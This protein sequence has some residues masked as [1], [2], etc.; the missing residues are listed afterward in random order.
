MEAETIRKDIINKRLKTIG[1][2]PFSYHMDNHCYKTYIHI[3]SRSISTEGPYL[4][5]L[6]K[7]SDVLK[8]QSVANYCQRLV[9]QREGSL[10]YIT[11]PCVISGQERSTNQNIEYV[12]LEGLTI[13]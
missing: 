12:N 6:I 2:E 13:S 3:G 9:T 4:Y 11:T 1:D 7:L 5:H 10:T 8:P